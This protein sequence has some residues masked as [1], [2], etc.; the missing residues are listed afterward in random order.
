MRYADTDFI[1]LQLQDFTIYHRSIGSLRDVAAK[2]GS[3]TYFFDGILKT[4]DAAAAH[5]DATPGRY[6]G[7][8]HLLTL[9]PFTATQCLV[10][11]GAP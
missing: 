1:S 3:A 8:L 11:D 2:Q 9:V 7:V 10:R 4:E 5:C 6:L